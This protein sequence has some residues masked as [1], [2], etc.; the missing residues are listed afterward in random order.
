MS[1]FTVGAPHID[2]IVNAMR[3]Y[4]GM[5]VPAGADRGI[6]QMLWN[7]NYASVNH[8][9]SESEE[10]PVYTPTLTNEPLSPIAVLKALDCYEYQ[11]CEHPG[12]KASDAKTLIDTIRGIIFTDH[13]EW[14]AMVPRY[15]STTEAYHLLPEYD[16]A[17]WEVDSLDQVAAVIVKAEQA[18]AAEEARTAGMGSV[19]REQGHLN[20]VEIAKRMRVNLRNAQSVGMLP[21]GATF[22]VTTDRYAGGQSVDVEVRGMPD[23]WTYEPAEP[24]QFGHGRY[25]EA[26]QATMGAIKQML[27]EY[28]RDNSDSMTDYF[29]V[30]FHAGVTIESERSAQWRAEEKA[31]KAARKARRQR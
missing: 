28:N 13:P 19:Y 9:Y 16:A 31:R 2:T 18:K 30:W 11:S 23:S 1:A 7:E 24:G 14:A 17:P 8:R 10:A 12:W 3:Q 29:D 21:E 20:I 15:G 27:A 5:P 22:S 26:A 25:S 4:A 6:G